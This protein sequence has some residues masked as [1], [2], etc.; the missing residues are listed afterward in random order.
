MQATTDAP[1]ALFGEELI[2]AYPGAKVVL[3]VRDPK[4]WTFSV[5]D[6]FLYFLSG[7]TTRHSTVFQYVMANRPQA[8]D[9]YTS[10]ISTP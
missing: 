8:G 9:G 5:M 4:K 6:N 1:C 3:N 7:K 2:E 10:E